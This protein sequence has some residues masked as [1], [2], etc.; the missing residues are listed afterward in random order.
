MVSRAT[1]DTLGLRPIAGRL[2][3]DTDDAGA[4]SVAVVSDAFVASLWMEPEDILGRKIRVGSEWHTVVGVVSDRESVALGR[5]AGAHPTVYLSVLQHS[6]ER[7]EISIQSAGMLVDLG[8]RDLVVVPPKVVDARHHIVTRGAF[9][10]VGLVPIAGRL[11]ADTDDLTAPKVAVV[12]R[13]FAWKVWS[14]PAHIVGSHIRV[15][16]EWHTVVGVVEDRDSNV[17]GRPGDAAPT[18]YLSTLQHAPERVELT[19]SQGREDS[20]AAVERAARAAGLTIVSQPTT[21]AQSRARA[22][23]PLAWSS[24]V[25]LVAAMLALVLALIGVVRVSRLEVGSRTRELA[26]R[27]ALG[28]TPKRLQIYFAWRV[29]RLILISSIVAIPLITAVSTALRDVA[30]EL[31]IFQPGVY[32]MLVG[33][34]L[35]AS[36]GGSLSAAVEAGRVAPRAAMSA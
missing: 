19:V 32:A 16:R 28:A 30:G 14:D 13:A 9:D 3:D 26:I 22:A 8:T 18:V 31:P 11:L 35:I 27:A 4:A 7:V 29:A 33:V 1:F 6:P 2:L 12:S 17:L 21:F 36:V 23:A 25:M 5:A 24:T 20:L 15:G 10:T 34:M